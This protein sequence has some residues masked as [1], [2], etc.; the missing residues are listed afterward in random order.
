MQR[1]KS[2]AIGISTGDPKIV[3]TCRFLMK[4]GSKSFGASEIHV[5]MMP[6]KT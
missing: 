3:G 6:L 5:V 4:Q 1:K 2:I